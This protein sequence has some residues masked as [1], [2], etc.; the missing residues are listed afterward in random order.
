MKEDIFFLS[1]PNIITTAGVPHFDNYYHNNDED[2]SRAHK[3]YN[4]DESK[5][6]FFVTKG[7]ILFNSIPI[8]TVIISKNINNGKLKILHLITRIHPFFTNLMHDTNEYEFC[9][10]VFAII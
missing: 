6:I 3:K 9:E 2:S 1:N 7:P 4:I 5:K 10:K 8:S